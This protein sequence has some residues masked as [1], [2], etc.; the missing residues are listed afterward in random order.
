VIEV[1]LNTILV[2]ALATFSIWFPVV[3]IN[4]LKR[5][6]FAIFGYKK[7]LVPASIGVPIHELSHLIMAVVF[8]HKINKV[9]FFKPNGAGG[10]GFV[11]HSYKPS[12]ITPFTNML[13]GLAPLAGGLIAFGVL[14]NIFQPGIYDFIQHHPEITS[15]STAAEYTSA[16][17]TEVL[18][19]D[20]HAPK[21][22]WL[23]LS[24]PIIAFMTPSGA[25]F[26]GCLKGFAV[27]YAAALVVGFWAPERLISISQK[28]IEVTVIAAPFF[29][30][31][32]LVMMIM[33]GIIW[34]L[35]KVTP[36]DNV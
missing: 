17:L 34:L 28:V 19:G 33:T 24:I 6:L 22:L 35:K 20:W 15:A 25:D 29:I 26:K 8:G 14:T 9:A 31:A 27:I 10:L 2:L 7:M 12:L 16:V 21:Y 23:C 13:I 11:E 1:L 4:F 32:I 36:R 3:L 5:Q 30:L 18:T